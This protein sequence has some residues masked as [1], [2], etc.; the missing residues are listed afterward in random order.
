MNKCIKVHSKAN[1][2]VYSFLGIIALAALFKLIIAII[3]YSI[4]SNKIEYFEENDPDIIITGL[5][6]IEFL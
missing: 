5:S 6:F 3:N 2:K 4:S 1:L